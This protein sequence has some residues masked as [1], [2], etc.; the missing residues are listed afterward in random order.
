MSR[1]GLPNIVVGVGLFGVRQ[2]HR[3]L[4]VFTVPGLGDDDAAMPPC[5]LTMS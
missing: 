1:V 3:H 5:S 2:D 4:S